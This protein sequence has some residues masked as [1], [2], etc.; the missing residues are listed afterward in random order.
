MRQGTRYKERKF[1]VR[2]SRFGLRGKGRE[3][4]ANTKQAQRYCVASSSRSSA[5]TLALHMSSTSIR[6]VR[7][8][9]SQATSSGSLASIIHSSHKSSSRV[10]HG[11]LHGEGG[12][13]AKV[14]GVKG[15]SATKRD[16]HQGGEH[17][18]NTQALEG[19][20]SWGVLFEREEKNPP[21][22]T[23]RTS[24]SFF[25]LGTLAKFRV[26]F[27]HYWAASSTGTRGPERTRRG[28]GEGGGRRRKREERLLH[29]TDVSL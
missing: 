4:G 15:S 7:S 5:V 14:K 18:N 1:A 19:H 9:A 22:V 2:A 25:L 26:F 6:Q 21:G 28:G 3:A 8:S 17:N 16:T 27:S 13:A 20:C 11:S 29:S 12:G 10:L 24:R 23:K